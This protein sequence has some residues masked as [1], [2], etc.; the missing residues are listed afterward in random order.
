V[1][2]GSARIRAESS[3]ERMP[4]HRTHGFQAPQAHGQQIAQSGTPWAELTRHGQGDD[5]LNA[6]VL[7]EHLPVSV[8]V[9]RPVCTL[10]LTRMTSPGKAGGL[11]KS[12]GRTPH[13]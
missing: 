1:E 2:F 8:D 7:D 3:G 12:D 11:R 9:L 13:I 6:K 10:G 5:L 4:F